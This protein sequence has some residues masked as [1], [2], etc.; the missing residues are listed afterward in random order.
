MT[1]E[2]CE[3]SGV[4]DGRR[5]TMVEWRGIIRDRMRDRDV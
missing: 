3:A 4:E 2:I 5:P 1:M